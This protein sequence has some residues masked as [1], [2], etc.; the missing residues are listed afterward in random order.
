MGAEVFGVG[1]RG[2]AKTRDA[3]GVEGPQEFPIDG[4]GWCLYKAYLTVFTQYRALDTGRKRTEKAIELARSLVG[5]ATAE[6]KAYIQRGLTGSED[7][8]PIFDATG[9]RTGRFGFPS[10]LPAEDGDAYVE[11]GEARRKFITTADEYL[12]AIHTPLIDIDGTVQPEAWGSISLLHRLFKKIRPNIYFDV[13]YIDA[14]G[15]ADVNRG[16]GMLGQEALKHV[17]PGGELHLSFLQ[18]QETANHYDVRVYKSVD[19]DPL[20]PEVANEEDELL[21]AAL[22]SLL[23]GSAATATEN[24]SVA[25]GIPS[26]E[27]GAAALD[28]IKRM[29][30]GLAGQ[31]MVRAQL[32]PISEA[33]A[34]E[35]SIKA[36]LAPFPFKPGRPIPSGKKEEEGIEL[37]GPG[38]ARIL[39]IGTSTARSSKFTPKEGR[40]WIDRI[41]EALSSTVPPPGGVEYR[42]RDPAAAATPSG[43]FPRISVPSFDSTTIPPP[44]HR[45]RHPYRPFV[46]PPPAP[47]PAAT[48]PRPART[49]NLPEWAKQHITE[50]NAATDVKGVASAVISDVLAMQ[51]YRGIDADPAYASY[52][53]DPKTRQVDSSNGN[54]AVWDELSTRYPDRDVLI[55]DASGSIHTYRVSNPFRAA[56]YRHKPTFTFGNPAGL[57]PLQ[58]VMV[59]QNLDVL[60][61]IAPEEMIADT[62]FATAL[63]ESL[64]YCGSGHDIGGDPRCFPARV[65]GELREYKMFKDEKARAALAARARQYSEWNFIKGVLKKVR[66]QLRGSDVV[67]PV[68][69]SGVPATAETAGPNLS[70]APTTSV[71]ELAGRVAATGPSQNV[72]AVIPAPAA[73]EP[74]KKNNAGPV[75]RPRLRP[76]VRIPVAPPPSQLGAI[77]IIPQPPPNT[78]GAWGSR[79]RPIVPA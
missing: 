76:L 9:S 1:V 20:F 3:L 10:Q 15:E 73:A 25:P 74:A 11:V 72:S 68:R 67:G 31:R 48:A 51:D 18:R 36:S 64:W 66:G 53:A 6:D 62:K 37:Q 26:V 59:Q 17:G 7:G 41:G 16:R 49:T 21:A 27:K 12:R 8:L 30:A 65:L 35:E 38:K 69:V 56:S 61:E 50:A 2:M 13:R 40:G 75:A 32:P 28:R 4:D 29:S 45:G 71:A 42:P 47:A 58:S 19:E 60:K 54:P 43:L 79:F 14:S 5:A 24:Q 52:K 39:P 63:L 33:A 34:P 46:A 55:R 22:G 77:G 44:R 57:N 70:A 23:L 78:F